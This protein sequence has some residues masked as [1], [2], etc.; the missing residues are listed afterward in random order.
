MSKSADKFLPFFK[1]LKSKT[2]FGWDEEAE[3]AFQRLMEYL[4]S[5]RGW[6][7]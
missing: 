3:K 7:A 4:E 1:V 6:S 5:S 2:R